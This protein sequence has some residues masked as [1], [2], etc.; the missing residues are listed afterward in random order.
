MVSELIEELQ[1]RGLDTRGL[2][3]D[4]VDRLQTAL[5]AEATGEGG[6]P[7][8]PMDEA[9]VGGESAE[10]GDGAGEGYQDAEEQQ[11]LH[12]EPANEWEAQEAVRVK[13]EDRH[14]P[15]GYKRPS[16]ERQG[17]SYSEVSEYKRAKKTLVGRRAD[18]AT[19]EDQMPWYP[20][21]NRFVHRQP[22]DMNMPNPGKRTMAG[23]KLR[24]KR[25][26]SFTATEMEILLEEVALHRDTLLS[27]FR[28]TMSN[29]SKQQLWEDIARKMAASSLSPQREWDVVRKKWHD[30]ASVA[31]ARGAAV[32]RDR[33]QT[34]G[35]PSAVPALT[36]NEEKVLDILGESASQGI[37]GGID[38][39][40]DEGVSRNPQTRSSS[41][42]PTSVA[43]SPSSSGAA[44][45]APPTPHPFARSPGST[46]VSL[47]RLARPQGRTRRQSIQCDCSKELVRLEKEKLE[48]LQGIKKEL[49]E[50]NHL[51]RAT[52]EVKR[53]KL[54]L[55]QRQ[56]SLAEPEFRKPHISV[57]VI[58]P[59]QDAEQSH[60]QRL[61][62]ISRP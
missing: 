12:P 61:G 2:K 59:S 4:L 37:L 55:M 21:L 3:A 42:P 46:A 50:A 31:K 15:Y 60:H 44:S 35:G 58:L 1:G 36:P 32:R 7:P 41:P 23:K 43:S 22:T 27:S 20:A 6:G 9:C 13:M 48:A 10:H 40:A 39:R 17:I 26:P 25:A 54:D 33:E 8:G 38:V 5:K 49:Q 47:R 51:A 53:A 52:L 11:H 57:P 16:H 56:H 14:M 29:K 28:S 24:K 18:K 34:G 19:V 30:F 45:P 62:G